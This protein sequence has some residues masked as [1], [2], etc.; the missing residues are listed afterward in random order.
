[1]A[2]DTTS[3]VFASSNAGKVRELD[4]LLAPLGYSV[5]AQGDL[6][7]SDAEET[8]TT[9]V[10]NALLKARHACRE[11]GRPA[12]ADDSGLEVDALNGAP[13]LYSARY[14]ERAGRGSGDAAN[15]ALLLEQLVEHTGEQARR[16]RF[17]TVV[18]RLRH[19]DDPSPLIASAAWEGHVLQA[20]DG[21]GGF[22]YDPLFC[23]HDTR[24]SAARL[25]T[26]TKNRL[27]HRG[28]AVAELIRLLRAEQ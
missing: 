6:G 15:N 7:V 28:K 13:G 25:D 20:L 16:A 8:A 2:T 1:M 21:E 26:A 17:R 9:F 24:E 27:S 23:N 22:G 5:I 11:T 4:A 18:V 19:V 3:I 12:I 10:E 14:A